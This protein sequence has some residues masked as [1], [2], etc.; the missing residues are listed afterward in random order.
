MHI[1]ALALPL[2]LS[3]V[4]ATATCAPVLTAPDSARATFLSHCAACHAPPTSALSPATA[5]ATVTRMQAYRV[6]L[7]PTER[8]VIVDYLTHF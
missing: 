2:L 6:R 5:D 8:A 1:Y 4:L 7:S 3:L